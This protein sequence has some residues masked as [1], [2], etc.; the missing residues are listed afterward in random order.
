MPHGDRTG[1]MGAGPRTGRAFGY[2]SGFDAPGFMHPGF[3][4]GGFGAGGGYGR[5]FGFRHRAYPAE[6]FGWDYPPYSPPTKEETVSDL[7]A[8][9]DWLRAQLETINKRIEELEE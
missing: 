3:R 4:H 9:A 2:C 6:S 7:K 5:G 8:N 1:P